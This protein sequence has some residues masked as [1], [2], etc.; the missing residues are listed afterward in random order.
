ML[1]NIV[2]LLWASGPYLGF[3]SDLQQC[4]RVSIKPSDEV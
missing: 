1:E 2:H 4:V 3:W